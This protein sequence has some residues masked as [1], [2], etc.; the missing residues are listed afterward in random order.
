[1]SHEILLVDRDK[2]VAALEELS[3]GPSV[4]EAISF[5]EV[6]IEIVSMS[7]AE[8]VFHEGRDG[9][10]DI[11][12]NEDE[13]KHVNSAS[14][15][16]ESNT[17]VFACAFSTEKVLVLF[18]NLEARLDWR[19]WLWDGAVYQIPKEGHDLGA[20]NVDPFFGCRDGLAF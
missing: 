14:L 13:D 8:A 6:N 9:F 16:F 4:F 3:D 10:V 18:D 7:A 19:R 15:I 1:M 5:E 11:V 12:G 17:D 2:A 20:P